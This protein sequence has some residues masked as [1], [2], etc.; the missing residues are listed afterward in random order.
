MQDFN[1][2]QEDQNNPKNNLD[3]LYQ[4]VI[5]EHG[6]KPRNFYPMPDYTRARIGHNP[7][8][9]DELTLFLDIQENR[10]KRI[11]FQGQGCA[12]F[13]ASASLMTEALMGKTLEEAEILFSEVHELLM[14]KLNPENF[15]SLGKLQVLKGVNEFPVRVKCAALAWRTLEAVIKN[16][17]QD[18]ISTE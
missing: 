7:L 9:G 2:H 1:N 13:T 14:G 10:I 4:E 11:S 17:A 16:Q 18:E 3:D 6:R 12:I 5:L 15:E 8:C